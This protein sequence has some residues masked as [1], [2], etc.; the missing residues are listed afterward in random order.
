MGKVVSAPRMCMAAWGTCLYLLTDSGL[1]TPLRECLFMCIV[2]AGIPDDVLQRVAPHGIIY[3][4][5]LGLLASMFSMANAIGPKPPPMYSEQLTRTSYVGWG[6]QRDK[7]WR[8]AEDERRV[9]DCAR[10]S[11]K[12]PYK[13]LDPLS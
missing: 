9:V 12:A 3:S 7:C 6:A 1:A 13:V 4:R 10:C 8:R 2:A 11:R 5:T